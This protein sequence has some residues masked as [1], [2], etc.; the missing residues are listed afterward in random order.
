MSWSIT[1]PGVNTKD[2]PLKDGAHDRL[3][4]NVDVGKDFEIPLSGGK[5]TLAAS[6]KAQVELYNDDADQDSE[7]VIGKPPQDAGPT[8]PL[9]TFTP[10]NAS[11]WLKYAAQVSA[12]AEG[13]GEFPFVAL[14]ASGSVDVFVADYRW[15]NPAETLQVAFQQDVQRLRMPFVLGDVKALRQ[16]DAL[17][18]KAHLSL[19]TGLELTWSDVLASVAQAFARQAG[20]NRLLTFQSTVGVTLSGKVS[21]SDTFRLVFS[22]QADAG[23][24]QV[25]VHKSSGRSATAGVSIEAKAEL[26]SQVLE[27]LLK[28]V[29]DSEQATQVGELVEGLEKNTL[30]TTLLPVASTLLGKLGFEVDTSPESIAAAYKDAK[31]LL[32]TAANQKLQ[33]AFEYE[34]SRVNEE[35]TLLE[36]EIPAERMDEVHRALV[37][38]KI[39]D[40]QRLVQDAWIRRYFHQKNTTLTR[41]WG[42]TLGWR[43]VKLANSKDRKK[44]VSVTQHAS[45]DH[46]HGPRRHAYQ[47]IRSYEHS[48]WLAGH[49]VQSSLDF[50]AD[51]KEFSLS[52]SP[53]EFQYGL[54]GQF[55]TKGKLGKDALKQAIDQ[56][57]VWRAIPEASSAEVLQ[58]IQSAAAGGKTIAT[59]LELRIDPPQFLELLKKM[60]ADPAAERRAFAVAL[61]RAL[62]WDSQPV[63][64][65]VSRRE[66]L[67][68]R[69]WF[70]YLKEEAQDWSDAHVPGLVASYL[71]QHAGSDG[72]A[73]ST[74]EKSGTA[75]T[76]TFMSVL[77]KDSIDSG[78]LGG[79]P[80]AKIFNDWQD[81]RTKLKVL[82]EAITA[83]QVLPKNLEKTVITEAF[84]ALEEAAGAPFRYTALGAWLLELAQSQGM[85]A[86][87]SRA[88][89]VT[90]GEE[91]EQTELTFASV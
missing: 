14:D 7:G 79:K 90:L 19:E 28:S 86:D 54:Y 33:A 2:K 46:V 58:R 30:A 8:Q 67:Y 42:F 26:S 77:H 68:T 23:P 89:V 84:D 13:S 35:A 18:F 48:G 12:K 22:R 57:V 11:C 5:A 85:L 70:T 40:I 43:D 34:Y 65:T 3:L 29:S 49:E 47:G 72:H 55:R 20:A 21:I 80:Y 64:S 9:P 53:D 17:V 15:H 6:L 59:R 76:G 10:S 37:S 82:R 75:R 24:F 56:A 74:W 16:R 69:L 41:S 87:I 31:E 81:L 62:P 36:L 66:E 38:G 44:L 32:E 45:R 78:N 1:A 25:S 91:G 63:R 88:F 50:K 73:A 51:M 71:K 52:P 83:E 4:G 61:A 39:R 60:G 27:S